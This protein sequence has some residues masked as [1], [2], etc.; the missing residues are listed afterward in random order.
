[1]PKVKLESDQ[2]YAISNNEYPD[3]RETNSL[4]DDHN[5]RGNEVEIY[6]C[7]RCKV[8][9]ENGFI[10]DDVVLCEKCCSFVLLN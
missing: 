3:Y 8:K 9:T 7:N 2:A 5:D 1:M 10:V 6:T 4:N